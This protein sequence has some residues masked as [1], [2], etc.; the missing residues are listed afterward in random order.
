MRVIKFRG[1]VKE[2]GFPDIW[3]Y[4]GLIHITETYKSDEDIQEC[5]IYQ[6]ID[7]QGVGFTVDEDTIGQY[8][9]LKDKNGVKIYERRYSWIWRCRRRRRWI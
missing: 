4:G 7:E 1:K 9:G 5:N 8:T 2:K 6:I 3:N